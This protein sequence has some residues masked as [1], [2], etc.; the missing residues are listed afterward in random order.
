VLCLAP[1][2]GT[3]GVFRMS[4]GVKKNRNNLFKVL[5]SIMNGEVVAGT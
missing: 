3:F 1:S 2:K 5:I 4:S